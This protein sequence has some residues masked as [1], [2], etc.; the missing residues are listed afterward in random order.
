MFIYRTLV[1]GL[2]ENTFLFILH[3]I[4]FGLLYI[5]RRNHMDSFA[6]AMQ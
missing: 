2:V 5:H 1:V 6:A 3:N 4:S